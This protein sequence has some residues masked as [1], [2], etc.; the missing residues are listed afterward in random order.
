MTEVI[1][2]VASD[3]FLHDVEEIQQQLGGDTKEETV[4]RTVRAFAKISRAVRHKGGQ[5]TLETEDGEMV[6]DV[7]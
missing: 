7:E 3:E 1:S 5:V 6:I 4:A 2:F